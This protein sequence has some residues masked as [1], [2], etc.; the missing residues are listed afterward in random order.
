MNRTQE[1]FRKSSVAALSHA[2]MNRVSAIE[3]DTEEI[4]IDHQV[5]IEAVP[6]KNTP[7]YRERPRF[8]S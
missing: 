8:R 7:R 5:L 4:I 3:V 2:M 1:E 6:V